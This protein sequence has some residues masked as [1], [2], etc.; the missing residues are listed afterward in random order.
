MLLSVEGDVDES[1]AEFDE[2]VFNFI[3]EAPPMFEE[4]VDVV[5]FDPLVAVDEEDG[6]GA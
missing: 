2:E 3:G 1:E 6:D 5:D 4:V